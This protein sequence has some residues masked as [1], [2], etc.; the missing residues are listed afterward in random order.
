MLNVHKLFSV[1][2]EMDMQKW[3][4]TGGARLLLV[5]EIMEQRPNAKLQRKSK[6]I[7]FHV[8]ACLRNL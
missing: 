3:N 8:G 1:G 2:D 5:G 4:F 7:P 6:S